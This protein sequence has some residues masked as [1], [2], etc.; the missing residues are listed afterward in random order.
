M[1][2]IYVRELSRDYPAKDHARGRW[3]ALVEPEDGSEPIS[4]ADALTKLGL[5]SDD[6]TIE[7]LQTWARALQPC[8]A[9]LEKAAQTL[10]RV[11]DIPGVVEDDIRI[12]LRGATMQGFD[13]ANLRFSKANLQKARMEGAHLMEARMEGAVLVEARM[14]GANLLEARMEGANLMEARMEEAYLRDARMEGALLMQARMER[15]VLSGARMKGAMLCLAQMEGAKL[16][17][18]R[19]EGANLLG[20]RM[21]GALLQG[22]DLSGVRYLAPDQIASMFG[23]ASVKLPGG[24]APGHSDWPAHWPRHELGDASDSRWRIWRANPAD[25]SPPLP[26]A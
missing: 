10:G 17:G 4:D 8:R 3:Q 24:V 6:I 13:L 26:P 23:D 22:Q 25:Y 15:V 11:L 19:M 21:N 20:A 5:N 7:A 1:L 12:D 2:S 18:A 16:D 14:D 9:D